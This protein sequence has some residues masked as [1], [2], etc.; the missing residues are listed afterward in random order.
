M[1]VAE[2]DRVKAG[3]VLAQID[4]VQAQSD[5][6]GASE[7]IRA[8]ES[9]ERA[10]REQ[11]RAAEADM[12]AAEARVR[13]AEQQ[14]KRKRE[15]SAEQLVAASDLDT[16]K[17][18]ADTAVAQLAAARAA[19][20]RA[21]QNLETAARRIAQARSQL[22]RARDV[23]DKTSIVSPID[24]VVTRL[25]VRNGEMVVVGIQNQP[26]TT[27]MTI[28]DLGAI[29]AEVRVAEADILNV[30]RDQKAEVT[31]EALPGRKFSGKVVE[32]GQA[33]CR[34]LEPPQLASSG[35]SSV[36]TLPMPGSVPGSRGMPTSSR[37]NGRTC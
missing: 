27:L 28:S 10:S 24:G 26:G 13:D 32:I 25:R 19:T 1:P 31:L 20:E 3:Q 22:V 18:A 21:R 33:R 7:Q 34:L 17:A 23:L 29:D 9:E 37:A 30:A 35:S 36:W 8:L 14:L 15:L 2:G 5:A 12:A 6:T 4:R 11:V 16:A